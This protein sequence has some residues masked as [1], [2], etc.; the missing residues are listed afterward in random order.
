MICISLSTLPVR[1]SQLR[2]DDL[3]G[4]GISG[5]IE[6]WV[7]VGSGLVGAGS[8]I[9]LEDCTFGKGVSIDGWPATGHG[10]RGWACYGLRFLLGLA[11]LVGLDAG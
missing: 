4:N 10:R 9:V 5:R 6:E 11:F 3:E 1:A 7:W 8:C 2:A